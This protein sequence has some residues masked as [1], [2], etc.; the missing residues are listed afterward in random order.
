M[1]EFQVML[2]DSA[3]YA[4]LRH[5]KQHDRNQCQCGHKYGHLERPEFHRACEAEKAVRRH[6]VNIIEN[7]FDGLSD[8]IQ[9]RAE[10]GIELA[11]FAISDGWLDEPEDPEADTPYRYRRG[12]SK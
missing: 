10:E 12:M 7:Y 4:R 9:Q 1:S 5:T 3:H 11:V 6:A 8:D 2:V